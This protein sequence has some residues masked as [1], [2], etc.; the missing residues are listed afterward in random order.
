[1]RKVAAVIGILR[2]SPP[3]WLISWWWCV[4]M[5]TDPAARKRSALKKACVNRWNMPALTNPAPRATN[6]NPSWLTVE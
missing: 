5:M 6:M 1:M 3:S 2:Q 4:P